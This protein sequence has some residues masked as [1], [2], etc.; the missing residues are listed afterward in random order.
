MQ[1]ASTRLLSWAAV[2]LAASAVA[3]GCGSSTTGPNGTPTTS[4]IAGTYNL[5]TVNGNTLPALLYASAGD[6]AFMTQGSVVLT[7]GTYA[8][9]GSERLVVQGVSTTEAQDD[10]GTYTLS[11]STLS[12]KATGDTSTTTATV[13]GSTLTVSSVDLGSNGQGSYTLVFTKQ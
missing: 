10:S 13:S 9:S 5:S 8:F 1:R 11:G 12:L 6:S 3:F 7:S 2:T 4:S